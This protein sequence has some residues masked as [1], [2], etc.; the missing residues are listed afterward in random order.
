MP[1]VV[2]VTHLLPRV[3]AVAFAWGLCARWGTPVP[4]DRSRGWTAWLVDLGPV[5]WRVGCGLLWLHVVGAWWMVHSAD[6]R[7]AWDHTA[8]VT[9]RMTGFNTGMGVLWNLV[10]LAAWTVDCLAGWPVAVSAGNP[11]PVRSRWRR[12]VECYLAFLWF[13]AAVVFATPA[14][15]AVMAVL[16]LGVVGVLVASRRRNR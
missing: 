2:C 10:A 7:Q 9:E 14:A 3:A 12:W 5:A 15:R 6:W 8:E 16:C 1:V 13:Q 11:A 4:G